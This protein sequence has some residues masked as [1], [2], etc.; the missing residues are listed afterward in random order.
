MIVGQDPTVSLV[1]LHASIIR[2]LVLLMLAGIGLM[3]YRRRDFLLKLLETQ[4]SRIRSW[5]PANGRSL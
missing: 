2:T 1:Y 5:I 3:I 4:T